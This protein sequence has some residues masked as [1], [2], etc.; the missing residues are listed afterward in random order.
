MSHEDPSKQPEDGGFGAKS[1][2]KG[3]FSEFFY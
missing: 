3:K 1:P 2:L